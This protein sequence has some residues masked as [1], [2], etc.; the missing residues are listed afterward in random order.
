MIPKE[1]E[2][3]FHGKNEKNNDIPEAE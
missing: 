3:V 1:L 2:F